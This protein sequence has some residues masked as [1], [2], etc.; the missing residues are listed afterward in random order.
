MWKS[1]ATTYGNQRF[2]VLFIC[3]SR[4][5][6]DLGN[7]VVSFVQ[8]NVTKRLPSVLEKYILIF[9]GIIPTSSSRYKQ[10]IGIYAPAKWILIKILS[11]KANAAASFS[12]LVIGGLIP[13]LQR[14]LTNES[15]F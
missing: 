2:R 12:L 9:S 10:K 14:Q 1:G 7:F 3:F 4:S 6:E 15:W 11:L 13:I 8:K 5:E